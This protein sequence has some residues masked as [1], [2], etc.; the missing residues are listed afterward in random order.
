MD[1]PQ[2]LL[3]CQDIKQSN[4][5]LLKVINRNTREKCEICLKLTVNI[6]HTFY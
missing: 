1:K 3:V 6:F 4:I 2:K 5:Y